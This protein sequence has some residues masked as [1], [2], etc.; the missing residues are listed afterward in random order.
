MNLVLNQS[1]F[2]ALS[3]EE[4]FQ[5]DGGSGISAAALLAGG[6]VLWAAGVAF[7]CVAGPFAPIGVG[8][9]C[10]GV[11][12]SAIGAAKIIGSLLEDK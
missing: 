6:L 11:I 1:S 9:A 12:C 3:E 4:M 2:R 8:V 10:A 5:V 7:A